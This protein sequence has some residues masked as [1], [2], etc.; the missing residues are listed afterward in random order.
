MNDSPY[1]DTY[2]GNTCNGGDNAG[3]GRT[4]PVAS[5]AGCQPPGGGYAGVY[6]LSG[7]V[8]EWEDSYNGNTGPNDYCRFRGGGFDDH[9]GVVDYNLRCDNAYY[10]DRDYNL[11]DDIGIRC[12]SAP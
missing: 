6:D 3:I 11:F 4:V 8:W 7:N 12:C 9:Y 2:S 1:G 10:L 5:M